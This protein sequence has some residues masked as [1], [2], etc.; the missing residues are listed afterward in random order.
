V[1]FSGANL[2]GAN[3]W[4]SYA[5][6]T[7]FSDMDLSK[8]EGLESVNHMGP[9]EIDIHTI[10]KSEGKIPEVFLRGCGL[11]ESFIVQIPA[12]VAAMQ[13]IQFYSCFISY[14]SKDQKFA[15]VCTPT[16]RAEGCAA[17]TRRRTWRSARR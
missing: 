7:A 16:S 12:L 2:G 15:S 1:N 13:P 11:P 10:Y 17:G 6:H 5:D 8:A 4:N 3:I 14:A 9:S